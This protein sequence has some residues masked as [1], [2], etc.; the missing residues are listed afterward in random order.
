MTRPGFG[1]SLSSTVHVVEAPVDRSVTV[2]TVPKA[3]VGLAQVPAGAP[4]HEACPVVAFCGGGGGGPGGA[5][6]GA[7]GAGEATVELVRYEA[8]ATTGAAIVV[9]V[10]TDAS[11][12]RSCAMSANT[13]GAVDVATAFDAV[14]IPAPGCPLAMRRPRAS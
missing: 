11:T 5:G 12:V 13:T 2:T 9:V 6:F 14:T 1:A 4:Y 7:G 8:L 3:S 10:A